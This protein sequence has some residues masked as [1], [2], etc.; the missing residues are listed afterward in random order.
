MERRLTVIL[1]ADIVGHSRLMD[2]NEATAIRQVRMDLGKRGKPSIEAYRGRLNNAAS[3]VVL[4]AFGAVAD[5]VACGVAF[6]SLILIER[7]NSPDTDGLWR[8]G[9]DLDDVSFATADAYGAGINVAA[10]TV[11]SSGQHAWHHRAHQNPGGPPW[12]QR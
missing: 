10:R 6:Q 9:I 2:S 7:R 4:A 3:E 5:A 11:L 12:T 1:H 8:I